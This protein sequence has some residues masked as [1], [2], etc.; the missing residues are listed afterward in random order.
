[1]GALAEKDKIDRPALIAETLRG[2]C[3][4]PLLSFIDFLSVRFFENSKVLPFLL[5]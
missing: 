4:L 2:M 5:W 1:M 3:S